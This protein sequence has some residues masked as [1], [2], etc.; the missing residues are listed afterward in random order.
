MLGK[1]SLLPKLTRKE[2]NLTI[3]FFL[4]DAYTTICFRAEIKKLRSVFYMKSLLL[5][6]ASLSIRVSFYLSALLFFYVER[7]VTAEK[8]FVVLSCYLTLRSVLTMGI[9]NGISYFAEAKISLDRISKL[10][11]TPTIIDTR[12]K[13]EE[14]MEGMPSIKLTNVRVET[15]NHTKIFEGLNLHVTSGIVMLTGSIGSG[16]SMLLKTILKDLQIKEGDIKVSN[17]MC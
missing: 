7:N 3:I 6:L 11:Q 5:C 15:R 8:V 4:I 17:Q 10:L 2:S 1:I 13:F 9:P 14:N 16:K 12:D